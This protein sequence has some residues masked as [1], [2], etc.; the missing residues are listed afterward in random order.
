MNKE[1]RLEPAYK[2]A[3]NSETLMTGIISVMNSS[4]RCMSQKYIQ[5]TA[6]NKR[7]EYVDIS[8]S[9][10]QA[11]DLGGWVL[12]SERGD[13]RCVI[14]G[15]LN[16]GETL[17][18]WAMSDDSDED[19]FNCGYG[20]TIWNNSESDPAVLYDATGQEVDRYP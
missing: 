20:T 19:G 1:L 4:G 2:P 9:G 16:P 18:V 11:Q 17:R 10:S 13:Q 8:N 3:E 6:V 7:A 12:V 15:V 5:I 14:G